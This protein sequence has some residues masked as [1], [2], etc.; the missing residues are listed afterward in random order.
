MGHAVLGDQRGV[1]GQRIKN[2]DLKTALKS[3]LLGNGTRGGE[4]ITSLIER[5]HYPRLG[6]GHD[7]GALSRPRRRRAASRPQLRSR[8]VARPPR[9]DE[10]V[11]RG[12]RRRARRQRRAAKRAAR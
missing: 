6:P 1:G 10:R 3:A 5:F 11:D 7:V 8:V 12:R 9:R 4:V 2:L